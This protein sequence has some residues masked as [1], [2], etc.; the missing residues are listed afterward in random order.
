MYVDFTSLNN[1]CPINSFP[2]SWIYQLVDAT[3]KHEL[4]TFMD[5]YSSYNHIKMHVSDQEHP[6]FIT[7]KWLY[8]YKVILLWLKTASA[9]YRMVNMM[10]A[11]QI[12]QNMEVYVNGLLVKIQSSNLHIA[13]LI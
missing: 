5:T 3:I 13:D 11:K 8:C 1:T 6:L 12:D 2:L 7:N 9:T 4:L 10:F